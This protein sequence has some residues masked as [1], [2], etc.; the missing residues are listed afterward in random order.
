[1][2]TDGFHVIS[3]LRNASLTAINL[4]KVA[5]KRFKIPFSI[6]SCKTIIHNAYMLE[7][8][9]CAFEITLDTQVIDKQFKELI[10]F[11][12]NVA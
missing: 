11:S 12:A 4:A 1:M 9:T 3:R 10:L 5:C 6:S 7:R 8:F 2:Y